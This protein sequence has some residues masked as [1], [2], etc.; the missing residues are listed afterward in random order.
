MKKATLKAFAVEQ[1]EARF[2][3][4]VLAAPI[5]QTSCNTACMATV[6]SCAVKPLFI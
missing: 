3:M 1:L 2:E 4:Q 5:D 6:Q